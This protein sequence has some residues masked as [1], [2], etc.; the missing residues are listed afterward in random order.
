MTTLKYPRLRLLQIWL[1]TPC[2]QN[3]SLWLHLA[4]PSLED[5]GHENKWPQQHWCHQRCNRPEPTCSATTPPP[6]GLCKRSSA[7][8]ASTWPYMVNVWGGRISPIIVGLK[9]TIDGRCTDAAPFSCRQ[10][11]S[12]STWPCRLWPQLQGP[13]PGSYQKCASFHLSNKSSTSS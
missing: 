6:F 10:L 2:L 1:H 11:H 3:P 7:R 9:T 8:Q 12:A 5:V 4:P 13:T